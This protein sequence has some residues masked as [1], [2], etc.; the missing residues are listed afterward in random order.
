M[1]RSLSLE[2]C[3]RFKKGL[4]FSETGFAPA[5]AWIAGILSLI[6]LLAPF[7]ATSALRWRWSNPA[8]HGNNIVDMACNNGL[9]IQVAERGQIYTS[10]DFDNWI[11]RDSH[12]TYNLQGVTFYG[13]RAIVTGENGAALYSDDGV[14]FVYTN[15]V[16]SDW[17]VAVAASSN[18]VVTVGDSA[19]IYTSLN[20][21]WWKR[22]GLPQNNTGGKW[23]RGVAYG[24]GVFVTVGEA[25]YIASST[26][27]TNWTYRGTTAVTNDLNR[28]VWVN[29]PNSLANGFPSPCFLAVGDGGRAIFS[30]NSGVAWSD[31]FR[32][33]GAS[34]DLYAVAG[35]DSTRLVAGDQEARLGSLITNVVVW[36]RQTGPLPPAAP[37]WTY[38]SALW[39]TNGFYL[40]AG[41]SGGIVE[42]SPSTNGT[43]AWS[44]PFTSPRDWLWQVTTVLGLYVAVGD[45]ARIMTSQDGID[46]TPE[47]F[48]F[49]NSVTSTGTVFFSVG[50]T[51]NLLIAAGNRGSLAVSPNTIYPVIT[52]NLDGST[53]T[54][55]V[56][57]L[58]VV[59]YP[60]PAPTTNDLHAVG[61]Y[62]NRYYLAGGNGTL[63][64]SL[65]GTNWTSLSTPTTDYLSS[66]EIFPGGAVVV[67]DNGAIL[68]STDG[69][70]WTKRTSGT[71]NWIYRVRY[72]LGKLLAVGENGVILTSSNGINWTLTPSGT[73]AWLNDMEMVTNTI[74][75]V[76]TQ[77]TVLASTNLTTWSS[78][79]TI[80][81]KSL[82]GATSQNGQLVVVGIEGVILRSQVIPD[83]TSVDFL[84][85]S[86]AAGVNVFSVAGQP[87]QQFTLDSS[88]NLVNWTTG[89]LLELLYSS[90]TLIFIQNT[91]SNAVPCQFY[92]T[93]LAP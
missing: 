86:R 18:L 60:M 30:T 81:G 15:L 88:T 80:T 52:T 39:E 27:G 20:G 74:Y 45:H 69:N 49:T 70:S 14:N 51:T 9:V 12:T 85:F 6:V 46:W 24:G 54:N 25:G 16:T 8:P 47:D 21:A 79:G 71:T 40:M 68:T 72:L 59:W 37:A 33:Q 42:G 2:R 92:R 76:G 43:Y 34:N 22:Q 32:I 13:N 7:E 4:L 91:G 31:L 23:L 89:P 58:G 5:P 50:G 17:L 61:F 48:P 78:I 38:Y 73:T 75:I 62:G 67:G 3:G 53:V 29:T 56:S 82:Y 11:P 77:G 41:Q 90:G 26:N 35:N 66:M 44:T 63:L 64:S 87:D 83:L 93:R 28:V 10:L 84:D 55:Q 1:H 65:N 36:P 19:A 57:S